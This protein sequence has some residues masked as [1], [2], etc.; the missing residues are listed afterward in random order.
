LRDR[1]LAIPSTTPASRPLAARREHDDVASHWLLA[2]PLAPIAASFLVVLAVT[3]LLGN[4]Y[5][6]GAATLDEVRGEMSP[7]A[8]CVRE[9]ATR[10]AGVVAGAGDAAAGALPRAGAAA[11]RAI[12]KTL[13][14]GFD[15]GAKKPESDHHSRDAR[16]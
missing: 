11:S 10:L 3:A 14:D 15:R 5:Q 2:S 1:L 6:V 12:T 13:E 7:A 9:R 8:A 16:R 4:P